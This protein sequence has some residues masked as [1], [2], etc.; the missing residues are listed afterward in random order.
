MGIAMPVGAHRSAVSSRFAGFL[1]HRMIQTPSVLVGDPVEVALR[2]V[3]GP[4]PDV[5]G[6][7]AQ[8][9]TDD[10]RPVCWR[11]NLRAGRGS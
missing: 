2:L 4:S 10:R 3:V 9:S 7:M 5:E 1:S 11:P 8:D 6:E